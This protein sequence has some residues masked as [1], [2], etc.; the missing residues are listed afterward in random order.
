MSALS[1]IREKRYTESDVESFYLKYRDEKAG[2]FIREV[3]DFIAHPKRKRGTTL[4]TTVYEFA[5]P[6]FMM[7]FQSG[8]KAAFISQGECPW[9]LKPYLVGKIK[10]TS[11]KELKSS[12]GLTKAEASKCVEEWFPKKTAYPTYIDCRRKA[13]LFG[14]VNLFSKKIQGQ[15]VFQKLAAHDELSRIFTKESLPLEEIPLF[16][17]ATAIVLSGKTCEITDGFSASVQ[18]QV[19]PIRTIKLDHI[20]VPEGA[21]F[22]Y[23]RVLPDGNLRVIVVTQNDTG[24]GSPSFAVDLINLEIDT[25]QYFCRSLIEVDDHQIPRLNLSRQLSFERASNPMISAVVDLQ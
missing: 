3:G 19:D 11:A 16:L 17:L 8:N 9:W 25:E 10:E 20:P 22:H 13:A 23:C 6:A 4:D 12:C 24:D 15:V 7:R 1:R 2:P 5:Q 14:M 18:L 21:N